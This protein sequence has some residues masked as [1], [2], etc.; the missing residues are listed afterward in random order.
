MAVNGKHFGAYTHR[1]PYRKINAI[2][3]KGDV[4]DVTIDQMYRDAYPQVPI[5]NVASEELS[6][7]SKF[8]TVPFL[9]NIP[10]GFTKNKII[11]IFGKVKMLPHSITI[12]LQEKPYFWPHPVI[13]L[14]LNPRFSNQ[15]GHHIVSMTIAS[16]IGSSSSPH[17]LPLSLIQLV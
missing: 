15:G 16:L 10:G 14:H 8:M 6:V 12:N 11:H 2:E 4:K 3:V 1:V 17:P 7:N 5:E 13:A 9:G